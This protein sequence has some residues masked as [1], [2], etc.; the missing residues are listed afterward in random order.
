MVM[1]IS[2][3]SFAMLI[4]WALINEKSQFFNLLHDLEALNFGYIALRDLAKAH[5]SRIHIWAW[6]DEFLMGKPGLKRCKAVLKTFLI[7]DARGS[8][9]LSVKDLESL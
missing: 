5:R 2:T 3:L 9:T 1:S 8:I 4:F 7:A 6:A